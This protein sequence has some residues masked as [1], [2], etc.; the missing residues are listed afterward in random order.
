MAVTQPARFGAPGDDIADWMAQRWRDIANLGP[1]AENAGRRLWEQATRAG[2]DL[3]APN[4]SDVYSLGA[5]YLSGGATSQQQ[6][7]SSKSPAPNGGNNTIENDDWSDYSWP[8][9]EAA[10]PQASGRGGLLQLAAAPGNFWD[11]VTKGCANC[12]GRYTPETMPPIWGQAPLT[13]GYYQ[14]KGTFG[15]SSEP[16]WSDKPQCN[17]QYIDDRKICQRAGSSTCWANSTERLGYCNKTGKVGIP[18]LRFGGR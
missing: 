8:G 9:N 17:Q 13:P 12:H 7:A 2:Q 18:L 14:R 11:Y 1:E 10:S 3:S 15:S 4:P 16:E 6:G 5:Q